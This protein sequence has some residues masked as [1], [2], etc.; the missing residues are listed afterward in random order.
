M[1]QAG[2]SSRGYRMAG[3][4]FYWSLERPINL[5]RREGEFLN[6]MDAGVC[7]LNVLTPC[8]KTSLTV[9]G[10]AVIRFWRT[11]PKKWQTQRLDDF[12]RQRAK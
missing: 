4:L 3:T 11:A 1:G 9:D 8:V 7:N 6:V 10:T 5:E 12:A 2:E